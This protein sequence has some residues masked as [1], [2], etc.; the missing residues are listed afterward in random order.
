MIWYTLELKV[1]FTYNYKLSL[2]KYFV[3]ALM[4]NYSFIFIIE[5]FIFYTMIAC[6]V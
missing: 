5:G 6:G 1:N 4:A 3:K 2:K